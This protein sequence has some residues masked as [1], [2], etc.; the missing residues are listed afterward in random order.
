MNNL[1]DETK[2]NKDNLDGFPSKKFI[3]EFL[4]GIVALFVVVVIE[5]WYDADITEYADELNKAFNYGLVTGIVFI[6]YI[7]GITS[8]ELRREDKDKK[9]KGK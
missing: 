2:K 6:S 8:N 1:I 4:L 9:R 7:V 5:A 3:V